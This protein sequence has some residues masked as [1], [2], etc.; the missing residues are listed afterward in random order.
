MPGDD[1]GQSMQ[2]LHEAILEAILSGAIPDDMLEKLL[3]QGLAACRRCRGADRRTGRADHPETAAAGLHHALSRPG[4]RATA[5]AGRRRRRRGRRSPLRDYRQESRLSRLPRAARPDGIDRQEQHRPPRHARDGHRHRGER[6]AQAIRIRRHHESRC[7]R[8]GAERR[9]AQATLASNRLRR[10]DGR[11]GRV[12]ELLRDRA[13]ARLQPQHDPLRRGPLHAGQAGRAGAREPDQ[14]AVSGR[15]AEMRP[16]PRFGRR[17]PAVTA[18]PR[19]R[20]AV[21][22]QHPRGPPPRAPHPRAPAEGHAADRDDHRRQAVG[23]HPPR[24][25]HLSQR[26]RPRSLH[27]VGDVRRGRRLPQSR[28]HDQ[29]VHAR[30]RSGPVASSARS[31]RSATARPTSPRRA[32][33]GR[34]VLMDYMDNKSRTIH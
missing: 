13:D 27:R 34:Y 32:R 33:S 11:A 25:P 16:L 22:H 9:Q 30:A 14:A 12:P 17:D 18:G 19:P 15:C 24:R 26:L 6:R 10:P 29:H 21:L 7:R 8:N 31:R 5:P 3:G 4:G 1:D 23:A 28:H 2:A 20:R